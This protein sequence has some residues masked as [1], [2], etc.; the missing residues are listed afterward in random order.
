[1]QNSN[2]DNLARVY[3]VACTASDGHQLCMCSDVKRVNRYARSRNGNE[4][5]V[6]PVCD[7]PKAAIKAI[8]ATKPDFARYNLAPIENKGT[9]VHR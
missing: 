9:A 8:L 4:R 7:T 5:F 2:N 6:I 1:M 3:V